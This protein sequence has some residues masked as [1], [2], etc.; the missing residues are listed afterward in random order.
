MLTLMKIFSQERGSQ[1]L[2]NKPKT[3]DED[4]RHF[5]CEI[6]SHNNFCCCCCDGEMKKVKQKTNKDIHKVSNGFR[7]SIWK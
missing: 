6:F 5:T 2:P 7:V 1:H 3:D 4:Q